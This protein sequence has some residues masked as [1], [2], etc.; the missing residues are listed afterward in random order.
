MKIATTFNDYFAELIPS[1]NLFRWLGNVT[2]LAKNLDIIHSMVL[3]FHNHPSIKMI[4]NKFR[5]I[6]KFSRK[7]I[8]DIPPDI[9]KQSDLCFQT[10]VNCINQSIIVESI[11]ETC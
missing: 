3:K 11:I 1:L 5:R 9:I 2:S 7:V 4:K 8:K 6:T 10:L